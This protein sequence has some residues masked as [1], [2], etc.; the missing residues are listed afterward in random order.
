MVRSGKADVG[1]VSTA[2]MAQQADAFQSLRLVGA[3][4]RQTDDGEVLSS[5]ALWEHMGLASVTAD[6]SVQREVLIALLSMPEHH[7]SAAA[8]G[9]RRWE[10]AAGAVSDAQRVLVALG[11]AEEAGMELRCAGESEEEWL[12]IPSLACPEAMLWRPGN[13]TARCE[14]QGLS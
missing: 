2:V 13:D 4:L 6:A 5:T 14:A 12:G 10:A 9:Y 7:P 1:F 8:A 3:K 11:L